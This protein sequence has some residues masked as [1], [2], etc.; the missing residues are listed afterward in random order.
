MHAIEFLHSRL[1]AFTCP[2]NSTFLGN[3][4]Q[5]TQSIPILQTLSTYDMYRNICDV[6]VFLLGLFQ[7]LQSSISTCQ[8][9]PFASYY[10]P[11]RCLILWK[12]V[13]NTNKRYPPTIFRSPRCHWYSKGNLKMSNRT[14]DAWMSQEVSKWL[15]A[16]F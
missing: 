11:S 14:S 6:F 10:A 9:C 3:T 4:W 15:V 16:W 12:V 7:L 2:N 13:K 1:M 8:K 5:L